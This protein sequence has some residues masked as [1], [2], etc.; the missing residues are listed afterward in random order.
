MSITGR[1]YALLE[2]TGG[3]ELDGPVEKVID[4][5]D[6]SFSHPDYASDNVGEAIPEGVGVALDLPRFSVVCIMNGSISNGDFITYSNLT[7]DTR[8]RVPVKCKLAE[9]T[10]EHGNTATYDI[11]FRKNGRTSTVL[12]TDSIV[13]TDGITID[14]FVAGLTFVKDDY[15]D[16]KYIDQGTNAQDLVMVVFFQAIT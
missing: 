12:Q 6:C 7:P 10:F 14:V 2:D 8:I 11:E 1:K 5:Q 13:A 15:L 3:V 16:I 9:V 4:G